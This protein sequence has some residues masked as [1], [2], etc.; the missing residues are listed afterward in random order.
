MSS[1]LRIKTPQD[2]DRRPIYGAFFWINDDGIFPVPR[3]AYYMA[4]SGGQTTLIIPIIPSHNLVVV[5]LGHYEVA[6]P[7][8]A[9]F[10]KALA[11][12]M[13][14]VPKSD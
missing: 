8:A 14:A 3:D 7:G 1:G 10:R 5:R 11:L 12:L 9:S 2:P 6:A 13:Q 4:G